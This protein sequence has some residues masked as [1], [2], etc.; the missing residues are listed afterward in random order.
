MYNWSTNE[1]ALKKNK[2]HYAIWRL[3]Q[4]VNFGL[5]GKKL[6]ISELRKYWDKLQID[7]VRRQFL[8]LFLHG[9][10]NP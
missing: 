9:K 1:K 5:H 4:M 6:K 8:Q 2:E 10:R 7:P 3:E